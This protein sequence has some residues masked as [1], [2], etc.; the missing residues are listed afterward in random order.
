MF[1]ID[2]PPDRHVVKACEGNNIYANAASQT[3]RG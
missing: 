1:F 2:P 3:K